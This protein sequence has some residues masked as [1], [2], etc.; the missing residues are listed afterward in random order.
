MA[1]LT[2]KQWKDV[3]QRLLDGESAN[4]IAKRYNVSRQAI[5]KKAKP[6]V[7]DIQTVANQ[8]ATAKIN[9][10]K[11]P[12]VA[13]VTACNLADDLVSMSMLVGGGAKNGA[14]T[15]YRLSGI[16]NKKAQRL[17]D[18]EPNEEELLTIARLTKVGN[19]AAAPALNLMAANKDKMKQA[20]ESDPAKD[21]FLERVSGKVLGIAYDVDD[22]ED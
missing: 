1:K 16:A 21:Q 8:L 11:L 6:A 20:E 15:F 22:D 14:M 9:L 7:V 13:Q 19:D 4:S 18:N 2:E 12:E 5:L 17:D 3:H 10:K